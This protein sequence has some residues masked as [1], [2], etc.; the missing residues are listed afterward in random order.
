[1]KSVT[2]NATADILQ[3]TF[4]GLASNESRAHTVRLTDAGVIFEIA[5]RICRFGCAIKFQEKLE[6]VFN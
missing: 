5:H 1:M 6:L 2:L 3:P 4:K